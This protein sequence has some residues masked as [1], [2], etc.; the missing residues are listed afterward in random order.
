ML[1][2]ITAQ[3]RNGI[4]VKRLHGM[5]L[6]QQEKWKEAEKL[7]EEILEED[8]ANIVRDSLKQTLVLHI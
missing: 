1:N 4:R 5:Q 7:Y 8:P 6:E 2:K 3:F